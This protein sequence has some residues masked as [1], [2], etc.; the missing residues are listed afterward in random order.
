MTSASV[1]LEGRGDPGKRTRR[2]WSLEEKRRLVSL[3][4]EPN[5]SIAGV[6]R[7]HDLNANLLFNWRRKFGRNGLMVAPAASPALTFAQIDLVAAPLG[8][9]GAVAAGLMEIELP[10]GA[11][12]RVDAQ[13]DELALRRVLAAL[14]AVA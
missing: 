1:G 6:A 5:A 14:K 7:R 10:G 13:V 12:V 9:G 4:Y 3:T 8:V 11:H 2:S